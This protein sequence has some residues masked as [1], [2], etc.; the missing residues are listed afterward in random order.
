MTPKEIE[1]TRRQLSRPT[2]RAN[3]PAMGLVADDLLATVDALRKAA[4]EVVDA[5]DAAVVNH[6]VERYIETLRALLEGEAE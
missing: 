5:W 3:T 2:F 1:R 6:D 4:Q